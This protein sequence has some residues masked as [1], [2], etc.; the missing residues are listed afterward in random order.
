MVQ[1]LYGVH[2]KNRPI[3]TRDPIDGIVIQPKGRIFIIIYVYLTLPSMSH[4]NH[5]SQITSSYCRTMV[6]DTHH[7]TS[8][9][10]AVDGATLGLLCIP[11][12]DMTAQ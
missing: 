8:H 11:D 12:P 2:M 7:H 1:Q 4:T 9:T 3:E 10:H 5:T 6:W